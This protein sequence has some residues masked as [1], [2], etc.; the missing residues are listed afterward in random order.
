MPNIWIQAFVAAATLTQSQPQMTASANTQK[1]GSSCSIIAK[2]ITLPSIEHEQSGL[3]WLTVVCNG[4]SASLGSAS[5]YNAAYNEASKSLLVVI[6]SPRSTRVISVYP[7]K[8]GPQVY[9]ISRP[10]SIK[11]GRLPD[12]DLDDTKFDIDSFSISSKISVKLSG[13]RRT[14][15]NETGI[16]SDAVAK[17]MRDQPLKL[18]KSSSLR[19]ISIDLT[20]YIE[21]KNKVRN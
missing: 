16:L 15:D 7:D 13:K 17:I 21:I 5:A 8:S 1:F 2:D 9:D 4:L 10:I 12:D 3:R 20:P 18:P 14:A 6:R 11:I 19:S